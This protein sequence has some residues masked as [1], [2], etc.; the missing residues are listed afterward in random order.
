MYLAQNLKCLRTHNGESMTYLAEKIGR[1]YMAISRYESGE[2]EPDIETIIT[3]SKHFNVSID[4]LL[5][6]EIKPPLPLYVSN[7]K[8]L[9]KKRNMQ[10]ERMASFLGVSAATYCKYENGGV[11]ISVEKLVKLADFFGV[12]LDQMV[13][14]D[15]S[16]EE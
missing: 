8:F 4:D 14:Q 11:E 10:Q 6:K 2:S 16:K 12:T 1:S 3:L 13:R 7:I 15:L 5:T 9:R